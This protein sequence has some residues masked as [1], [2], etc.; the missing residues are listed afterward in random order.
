[1]LRHAGCRAP[2]RPG[3]LSSWQGEDGEEA[4]PQLVFPNVE[5]DDWREGLFQLLW[6]QHGGS[7][8]AIGEQAALEM[9]VADRDWFVQRIRDQREEEAKEIEKAAKGK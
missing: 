5:L 7:G 1:M 2:F 6:R 4:S 9:S 8:L 3:V